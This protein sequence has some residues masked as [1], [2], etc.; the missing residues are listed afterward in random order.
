MRVGVACKRG[1]D[2]GGAKGVRRKRRKHWSW[3]IAESAKWRTGGWG[4]G[5]G[6]LGM[7]GSGSCKQMSWWKYGIVESVKL[8]VRTLP[9]KQG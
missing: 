5:G 1:S 7:V 2:D 4:K 8:R 6:E 9:E 3:Q